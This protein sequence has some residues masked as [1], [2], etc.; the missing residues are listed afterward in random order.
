MTTRGR[1]NDVPWERDPRRKVYAERFGLNEKQINYLFRGRAMPDQLDHCGDDC[2]RR[3]LLG[4]S[5]KWKEG[6]LERELRRKVYAERFGL[7]EKQINYL[8][9]GRAML[10]QLDHCGDDCQRRL[11]LGISEKWKEG[12]LERELL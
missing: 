8:F 10:D 2:Q 3:L 11:L 1:H 6:D 4:I 12:D 7:N 9:R 5:E